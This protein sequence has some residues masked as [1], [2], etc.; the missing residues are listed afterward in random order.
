MALRYSHSNTD[1]KILEAAAR[2]FYRQGYHMTGVNQVIAEADVAKAS[3]Y[4]HFSSK[5]DLCVAYLNGRH[6]DWFSQLQKEVEEKE[7][8]RERLL[9]LFTFLE[10]WLPDSDFR[11]CAFLNISSE[12]PSPGSRVRLLVVSHKNALQDYIKQ[13]VGGLDISAN[14]NDADSLVNTIYLL[15]EGAINKGQVYRSTEFIQST[16]EAVRRLIS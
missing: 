14:E 4:C 9:G 12:F 10:R 13:L 1:K 3:F 7:D 11:G 5:E 6:Q 2:L 16:L 15:F 8:A